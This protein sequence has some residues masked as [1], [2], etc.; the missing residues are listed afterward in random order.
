[1]AEPAKGVP[2]EPFRLG[3]W[4]VE[5]ELGRLSREGE[6]VQLRPRAMEVLV[7][8]AELEGRLASKQHLMDSVWQTEFV[9]ANALTHVIA[10]LRTRLGDDPEKPSYIE[11]IPR[12]G[13]RVIAPVVF[14]EPG[15]CRARSEAARF[16]LVADDG[17]YPLTEGENLIG[18][19]PD[20]AIRIDS[21][22]V[23]RRHARI[24]VDGDTATIED[25]D[26]KNGTFLR[27]RRL[28]EPARLADADEIRIGIDIARFR[29][30]VLDDRTRTEQAR[31]AQRD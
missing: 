19:A 11:T 31:R 9:S 21:S 4:T 13:Y 25:L 12:R 26:S 28:C 22:E 14:P 16:Q 27:G 17:D 1:M 7:C 23:S 24:L 8:L 6:V 10:E 2:R 20:A 18:R 15:R 3:E 5:P 29:F 30:V